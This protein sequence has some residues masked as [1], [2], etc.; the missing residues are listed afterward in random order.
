[1][2]LWIWSQ[3]DTNIVIFLS[4]FPS[5]LAAWCPTSCLLFWFVCFCGLIFSFCSSQGPLIWLVGFAVVPYRLRTCKWK[6][7][8]PGWME[9]WATWS[10]GICPC[11]WQGDWN[12]MIFKVPS[13]P[14]HYMIL[15]NKIAKESNYGVLIKPS[16][17]FILLLPL[18]VTIHWVLDTVLQS[19]MRPWC[20]S[21]GSK[22]QLTEF[23]TKLPL[24][25]N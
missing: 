10:S 5:L 25:F 15:W 1:M 16:L 17:Q 20:S 2:F 3:E 14:Y 19:W 22:S 6:C 12:Q 23:I 8:R 7:S 9:L 24:I 4:T 18:S 21:R 13:N 11:S